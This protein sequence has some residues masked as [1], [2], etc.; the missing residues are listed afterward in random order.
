MSE[1]R[2]EELQQ[3]LRIDRCT[4]RRRDDGKDIVLRHLIGH[5]DYRAFPNTR[6]RHDFGFDLERGDVLATAPDRILHPVDE[7]IIAISIAAEGIPGVE[8]AVAPGDGSRFGVLVI[9][10]VERPWRIAANNQLADRAD[11]HFAIVGID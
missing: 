4:G 2:L 7:E 5:R 10:G 3:L 11:W 8:P 9:A 1:P 6:V